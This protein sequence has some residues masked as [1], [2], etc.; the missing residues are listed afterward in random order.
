MQEEGKIDKEKN[1]YKKLEHPQNPK[2]IQPAAHPH[3]KKKEPPCKEALCHTKPPDTRPP[4]QPTLSLSSPSLDFPSTDQRAAARPLLKKKNRCLF[5]HLLLPSQPPASPSISPSQPLTPTDTR[6]QH[7]H[8]LLPDSSLFPFVFIFPSRQPKLS[9][10]LSPKTNPNRPFPVSGPIVGHQHKLSVSPTSHPVSS[11][12]SLNRLS[13]CHL[14][15][16][17]PSQQPF[18]H[19]PSQQLFHHRPSPFSKPLQTNLPCTP[20]STIS[21]SRLS[22]NQ[23]PVVAPLPSVKKQA[24]RPPHTPF[25][26]TRQNQ[27]KKLQPLLP[28]LRRPNNHSHH[29]SSFS[30]HAHSSKVGAIATLTA[31]S[32]ICRK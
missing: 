8:S 7:Q 26:L 2:P 25:I 30:G 28:P 16:A 17:F 21:L 14:P 23:R 13:C 4:L 27:R 24:S 32:D 5:P 10:P 6:P 31:R 29:K 18:H 20:A 11:L 9:F 15:S 22:Q 12:I 3:L 19:R 1:N